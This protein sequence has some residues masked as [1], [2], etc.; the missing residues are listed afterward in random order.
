[1]KKCTDLILG[2]TF[3]IFIFFHFPDSRLSVLKD[4]QFEFFMAWQWRPIDPLQ[5]AIYVVQNCDAREK[6]SHWDKKNKGIMYAF[7][8]SCATATFVKESAVFD[9][10]W[11]LYFDVSSFFTKKMRYIIILYYILFT[12]KYTLDFSLCHL[13]SRK[14]SSSDTNII[15]AFRLHV[16]F[17]RIIIQSLC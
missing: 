10:L 9:V 15:T 3:C 13:L 2:Q 14:N 1:M 7:C 11:R 12:G 5:L 17:M 16:I 8:L 4:F 6:K